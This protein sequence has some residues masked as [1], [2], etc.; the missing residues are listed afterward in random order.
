MSDSTQVEQILK[1][2]ADNAF[3]LL[4]FTNCTT[5]ALAIAECRRFE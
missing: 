4:V 3:N 1:G 2:I 5:V